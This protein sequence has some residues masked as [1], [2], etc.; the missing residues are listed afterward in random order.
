MSTSSKLSRE[1]EQRDIE[2]EPLLMRKFLKPVMDGPRPTLRIS[3]SVS[4]ANETDPNAASV[5]IA[6]ARY[7]ERMG[8]DDA[9]QNSIVGRSM[10][11]SA[12]GPQLSAL[13]KGHG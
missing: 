11:K 4:A 6:G 7:R 10:G 5:A 3:L 9:A 8:Y 2:N 1:S 12:N 13:G